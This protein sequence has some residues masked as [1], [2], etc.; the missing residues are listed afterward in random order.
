MKESC[1]KGELVLAWKTRIFTGKTV[2][3]HDFLVLLYL[4]KE[5]FRNGLVIRL[6]P[7]RPTFGPI[8]RRLYRSY[9][10]ISCFKFTKWEKSGL[11]EVNLAKFGW[12]KI[13]FSSFS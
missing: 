3:F 9:G 6:E 13:D 5:Y 7:E 10:G 4:F 8:L 12:L 11:G 1:L 2:D